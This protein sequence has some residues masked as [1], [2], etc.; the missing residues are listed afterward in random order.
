[1]NNIQL[2]TNTYCVSCTVLGPVDTA[3]NREKK[4]SI[5]IKLPIQWRQT[6]FINIVKIYFNGSKAEWT[7]VTEEKKELILD[8]VR[9][10]LA[11]RR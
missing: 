6:I 9:E 8:R 2:S 1:M 10:S 5:L 4:V 7:L 11:L 3:V